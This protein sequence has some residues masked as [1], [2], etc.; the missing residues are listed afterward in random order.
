M[1]ALTIIAAGLL[2]LGLC[3]TVIGWGMSLFL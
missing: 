1:K 2:I 3:A